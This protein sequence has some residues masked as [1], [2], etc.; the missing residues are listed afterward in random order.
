MSHEI[1]IIAKEDYN[2]ATITIAGYLNTTIDIEKV[3]QFLP[4]HHL[5]DD[6][7][8]E[9]LKL[10]SG[11][12]KTIEYMGTEGVFIS[13]CYKKIRRG[14]RTGAMNNMASLDIQYGGKNIH[15]KLSSGSITSVGTKKLE[16]GKAVF[17]VVAGAIQKLQKSFTFLQTVD[18]DKIKKY[19]NQFNDLT[20]D[21]ERGLIRQSEF[22]EI[23]GDMNLSK[24]K[25]KV[26][27]IFSKY[28]NDFDHDEHP[29]L[30]QKIIDLSE[31]SKIYSGEVLEFRNVTIYNSVFHIT[32]IKNIGKKGFRMPLYLLAPFFAR[33]RLMVS[34]HN[35]NSEGV[36]VCIDALEEKPGTNHT[37]KEYKHRF[38]IQQTG[39]IRQCS[40][41]N[42]EEAYGNYLGIMNLLKEFFK[43]PDISFEE[44]VYDRD[45]I[46][47][48]KIE[49]MVDK[50][51]KKKKK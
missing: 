18:K 16:S 17:K 32:P 4:V 22:L 50:E 46:R 47:D 2:P 48:K 9:R 30:I 38:V 12:R 14:M 29:D 20:Y 19:I 21:E 28:I 40:P 25:I 44:Y 7:T 49:K 36:N 27:K 51:M 6:E 45:K 39:K 13:I 8:D 33:K 23:L 37:H 1:E 35:W 15:L 11:S 31:V 41:T 26:F 42:R 5:F 10:K 43:N 24:R 3:T 34:Y